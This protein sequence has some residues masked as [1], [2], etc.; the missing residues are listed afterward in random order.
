MQLQPTTW[1]T[2]G[3]GL[4]RYTWSRSRRLLYL[5]LVSYLTWNN[6]KEVSRL[7]LT[8]STTP[9]QQIHK[10]HASLPSGNLLPI[11]P[12]SCSCS[13]YLLSPSPGVN[14]VL[15]CSCTGSAPHHPRVELARIRAAPP[16]NSG[17]S[18][19]LVAGGNFRN[20]PIIAHFFHNSKIFPSF[21][22]IST[23]DKVALR[24]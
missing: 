17:V 22:S 18:A 9:G 20:C 6:G 12:C 14:Q 8:S 10:H 15:G 4:R 7:D 23:Q 1:F 16:G 19:L 21:E 2:P 11:I 5:L 24:Q 13:R 3:L